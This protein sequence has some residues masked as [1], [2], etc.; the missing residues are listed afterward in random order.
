VVPPGDGGWKPAKP[1]KSTTVEYKSRGGSGGPQVLKQDPHAKRV[2]E[3]TGKRTAN[4]SYFQMSD[5]SVQQE[6]STLPV[7]YRDTKG[8]WL[9]IDPSVKK[10]AARR[11]HPERPGKLV[12]HVLLPERRVADAHRAGRDPQPP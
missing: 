1:P 7:H 2:K 12:P 6:I 4:A 3:L 11:V 10:V 9:S 8:A 5:G